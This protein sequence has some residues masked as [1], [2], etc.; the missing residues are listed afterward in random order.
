MQPW[1]GVW[2]WQCCESCVKS[3]NFQDFKTVSEQ[4][5]MPCK[6]F[7]AHALECSGNFIHYIIQYVHAIIYVLLWSRNSIHALYVHH[8]LVQ[9]AIVC[10][11]VHWFLV[12]LFYHDWLLICVA[13]ISCHNHHQYYILTPCD[14][15]FN[16]SY[17]SGNC[18]LFYPKSS[19]SH[20]PFRWPRH[21]LK[22]QVPSD[23]PNF[24]PKWAVSRWLQRWTH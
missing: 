3:P 17:F 15:F 13:K 14:M 19:T 21:R 9:F 6:C 1:E 24:H 5:N 20:I 4:R 23:V 2:L 22:T 18:N 7:H 8:R 16:R 11:H 12:K 10:K